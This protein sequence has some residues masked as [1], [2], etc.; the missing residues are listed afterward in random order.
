MDTLL[1]D[2][3]AGHLAA[4]RN[5]TAR[6]D[7]AIPVEYFDLISGLT[8]L[9]RY[10]L[11]EP[12]S[13]DALGDVLRPL[14]AMT[15]PVQA[16]GGRLP[17]WYSTLP[18]A[19][20]SRLHV[21]TPGLAHGISGP[22]A[23]LSL[24]WTRGHRVPGQDAA[25]RRIANWLMSWAAEDEAGPYWPSLISAA[26]ERSDPRPPVRAHRASWCY[27]APGVARALQLAGRAVG[28]E[29]WTRCA[30]DAVHAVHRRSDGLDGLTD[31]GLCH[32]LAGLAQATACVAAEAADSLLLREAER[33]FRRVCDAYDPA[34]TF[35]YRAYDPVRRQRTDPPGLLEG[36]CG[37][38]LALHAHLDPARRRRPAWEAVLL[39]S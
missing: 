38:A 11:A 25:I 21:L 3:L 20:G 2:R 39:L 17:G 4:E 28:E 37:I 36:A 18:S 5:R 7:S 30:V 35:G 13:P 12:A 33:V 26:E 10:F 16:A 34:T 27:G 15:E 29:R 9:G 24:A 31:A 1:R 14:V 32:G 6:E 23:L 8:G 19:E 22:L